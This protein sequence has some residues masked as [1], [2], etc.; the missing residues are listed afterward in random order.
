MSN[1]SVKKYSVFSIVMLVITGL[2]ILFI[3]WHST[4]SAD[5][6]T[7]ESTNV[8]KIIEDFLRFIGFTPELTDHII[9]KTAHFCEFALLGCLAVWN[10]YLINKKLLKNFTTVGF[11]CLSAAVVDELIQINSQ[12]RSAEVFD[13]ALDFCGA[14]SGVIFFIIVISI[15]KFISKA[16]RK[17]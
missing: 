14:L 9:R 16:K 6:S 7:V 12:G 1:S 17:V 3:W 15:I 10:G 11:V 4:L 8:L 13:V 5:E 2:Y